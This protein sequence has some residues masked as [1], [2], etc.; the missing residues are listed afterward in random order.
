MKQRRIPA[1]Y[2]RG[3]TSKGIFIKAEDLPADSE[4]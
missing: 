2:M 1:V 4:K 3:G